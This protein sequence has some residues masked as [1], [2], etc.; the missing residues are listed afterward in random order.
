MMRLNEVKVNRD[1][2]EGSKNF[3]LSLLKVGDG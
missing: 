1:R 3:F 2:I